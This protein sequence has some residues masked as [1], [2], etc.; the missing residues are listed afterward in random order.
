MVQGPKKI[1]T[2]CCFRCSTE[3]VNAY[4][5]YRSTSKYIEPSEPSYSFNI[6]NNYHELLLGHEYNGEIFAT[7]ISLSKNS[8]INKIIPSILLKI[9]IKHRIIISIGKYIQKVP[10]SLNIGYTDYLYSLSDIIMAHDINHI[11]LIYASEY[12][13]I[14]FSSTLDNWELNSIP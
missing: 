7:A 1:N 14:E 12:Y 4:E 8:K 10:F 2:V 6:A 13:K 3:N 11:G 5:Y 9:K